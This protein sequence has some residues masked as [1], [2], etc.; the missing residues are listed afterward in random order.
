[1]LITAFI[2]AA[3]S[4]LLG[5]H[6]FITYPLSLLLARKQ[7]LPDGNQP[8]GAGEPAPSVAI[9]MSVFNE[10][11]VIA[12]KM[13]SLLAMAA[14]YPGPVTVNV[15]VDGATDST[16]QILASYQDRA[17]IVL[18]KERR[19]KTWGMTHLVSQTDSDLLMFTDANVVS[20]HD[21]LV[22][23]SAPF[24]DPAVGLTSARL[25]Y[26]NAGESVTS[27]SGAAYWE[28]EEAIK[29]IESQTVG[30]VGVDGAMF[31]IR[32]SL[33]QAPPPHLIDDL[34]VS[35]GVLI[36]EKRIISVDSVVVYER[37]AALADEEFNRKR[38]IACQA[39]N[40]H[41]T[42]WPQLRRMSPLRLY[43]YISHRVLKWFM[44]IFVMLTGIALL[45]ILALL[46]GFVKVGLIA[47]VGLLAIYVASL[48][49]FKPASMMF[50]VAY[51]LFG[52]A[53]GI[54][55][56]IF[57]SKTYTIWLPANSVRAEPSLDEQSAR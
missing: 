55:E 3:A 49:R 27:K 16:P 10:E 17:N 7:P 47:L 43:G 22:G 23:L 42:L 37:S 46:I 21:A 12:V 19:G 40:V 41:R 57:T 52:V 24:R 53:S 44:P 2:I 20:G 15:F 34:Y 18:S 4:I 50:S 9:C 25:R 45:L 36:A 56:A 33:Y 32:R 38:R 14:A 13:D 35:L 5:I 54:F 30:L 8:A 26:N 6:P 48:L 29:R 11:R 28:I 51:S 31:M 1:M 39:W